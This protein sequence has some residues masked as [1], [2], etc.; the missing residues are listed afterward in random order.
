MIFGKIKFVAIILGFFFCSSAYAQNTQELLLAGDAAYHRRSID[1]ANVLEA[2][3]FWER[4]SAAAPKESA[5][6]YRLAMAYSFLGRF[7]KDNASA[8]KLFLK[9]HDYAKSAVKNDSKSAAAHYWW[10]VTLYNSVKNKTKFAKLSVH[11]D[12][13]S[14]LLTARKLDPNYQFGGP[15]RE[16]GRIA[17]KSP[18]SSVS[19]ALKYLQ[20][21]YKIAPE[22]SVNILLLAEALIKNHPKLYKEFIS[23]L[24]IGL[25]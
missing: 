18:V 6:F 5:P 4:A 12:I 19:I 20:D 13:T 23:Y 11:G 21:S 16:L 24:E 9:G 8:E 25:S 15:D 10:S 22:Y 1:N 7:A 17:L 3:K 2:I 14:H